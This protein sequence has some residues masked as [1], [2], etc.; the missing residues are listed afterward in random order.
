MKAYLKFLIKHNFLFEKKLTQIQGL[1]QST[2]IE[3]YKNQRFLNLFKRAFNETKFYRE[4][5]VSHGISPN[6]IKSVE[7]LTKLPEI[8]KSDV[9]LKSKSIKR[10][11]SI[12][13]F[14]GFTSG[15]T[16]TPLI[17][18]RDYN[19]ILN[20]N[21]Y[22]W[23]YRLNNGLNPKDKKISVR[24]DLDRNTVM[25]E[26]KASN[27]LFISSYALSPQRLK[28]IFEA[29]R[30]YKPKAAL[31]YP[32]SLHTLA[33][34]A[35]ENKIDIEIPLA[36]TSSES[37][38]LHQEQAIK[39]AFSSNI[40]DWYGNAERTIALYSENNRYKEPLGYSINEFCE[41]K[42]IT[43]SL[44]NDVFPLIRY[45]VNDIIEVVT[46]NHNIKEPIEIKSI[47]GR[48][49][50]SVILPDGTLIGRLDLVFKGVRN[51]LKAQIIQY[52][53]NSIN[54]FLV[55]SKNFTQ[56]RDQKQLEKNLQTR[57]G[58]KIKIEFSVV[59]DSD[60][61]YTKSGKFKFVINKIN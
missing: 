34:F 33:S 22:V 41:N 35:I 26:D 18:Y 14:K 8:T 9:R 59:K 30:L 46:D 27:T 24:G 3:E 44:I 10:T 2:N 57:L 52:N 50:D 47:I 28:E 45:E 4:L 42:I 1:Y 58:Q 32:S 60:L 23:W 56:N 40:F 37:L 51:I 39:S 48:K 21:A 6:D 36:F 55:T 54:V 5:Y 12:F 15:T 53:V 11:N 20:E 61:V 17:V 43:T 29:V 7:D 31:G 49:E 38:L 13:T 25:Y 19:S 16:G